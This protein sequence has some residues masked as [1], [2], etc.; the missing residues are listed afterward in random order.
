VSGRSGTNASN[1]H[2]ADPRG[3]ASMADGARRSGAVVL[4]G[5]G[6]NA[7][8]GAIPGICAVMLFGCWLMG[9]MMA[10]ED[11]RGEGRGRLDGWVA[12]EKKMVAS[13]G[14]S[15]RAVT[16]TNAEGGVGFS[17]RGDGTR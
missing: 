15:R 11:G 9:R 8:E 3:L 6:R 12:R 17:D 16:R 14:A 2:D 13:H 10:S 5:R 7:R 4:D 1:T